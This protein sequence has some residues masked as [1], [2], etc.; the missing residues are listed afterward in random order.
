MLTPAQNEAVRAG[1]GPLLVLAGAGSG[2]TRVICERILFLIRERHVDPDRIL[3]ITFTRDAAQEMRDRF[4]QQVIAEERTERSAVFGTF[5]SVFFHVLLQS[6]GYHRKDLVTGRRRRELLVTAMHTAGI[7]APE[8]E[9]LRNF[10]K[11]LTRASK[12]AECGSGKFTPEFLRMRD[13][14]TALKKKEHL[15]DFDDILTE[16][17]ALFLNRPEILREWHRRWKY[18]LVDEVQDLDRVQN[19]IL[20]LLAAPENNVFLVGD[21]DQ[22]IYGFR[23]ASP[24]IMLKFPDVYPGLLTVHLDRNFRCAPEILQASENLIRHNTDRYAKQALPARRDHGSI[25]LDRHPDEEAESASIT[26]GFLKA[27]RNGEDLRETAVLFRNRRESLFLRIALSHAGVP[28]WYPEDRQGLFSDPV[29]LDLATY[30]RIA[31]GSLDRALWTR[32]RNR[33]LRLLRQSWFTED[34]V[35]PDRIRARILAD[36]GFAED[37]FGKL[38]SDLSF[39]RELPP[40]AAIQYIRQGIGYDSFLS[41]AE[42]APFLFERADLFQTASEKF[43][44]TAAFLSFCSEM[45]KREEEKSG[46]QP[47]EGVRLYTFHGSKGL[48]FDKVHILDAVEGITPGEKAV[49]AEAVEEERR[50]FYVALTRARNALFLHLP[51]QIRGKKVFP[52]RFLRE[53]K[54]Q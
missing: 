46:G 15:L 43:K 22:A 54:E 23:G 16:T 51:E 39:I 41:E 5:H 42:N 29:S 14:Y 6:G 20:L 50:M 19:R 47:A 25:F 17:L 32:I 3:V 37:A 26:D 52:S 34:P 18:I 35:E 24:E 4:L 1:D 44:S 31:A 53:M 40:F 2:K 11:D 13:A 49:T 12:T 45:Q 27:F 9:E 33:P 38:L 21:D 7:P 28:Y 30:L 36:G 10:E 48:E 8:E